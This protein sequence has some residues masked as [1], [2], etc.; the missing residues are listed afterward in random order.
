MSERLLG[1]VTV[2]LLQKSC[3]ETLRPVWERTRG[4]AGWWRAGGPLLGTS[5]E[6]ERKV[7]E[8]GSWSQRR[9]QQPAPEAEGRGTLSAMGSSSARNSGPL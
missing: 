5:A 7:G 1:E 6:E 2:L 4:M 9:T 8:L 3:S